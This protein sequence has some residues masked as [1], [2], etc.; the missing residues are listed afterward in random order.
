MD[1]D[2]IVQ[3]DGNLIFGMIEVK[4]FT[5]SNPGEVDFK[6]FFQ[7]SFEGKLKSSQGK[8]LSLEFSEPILPNGKDLA[9]LKVQ[10]MI[11]NADGVEE[12]E[13]ELV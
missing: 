12:D 3:I 1:Q 13:L 11:E 9:I 8:K 4:N 6:E 5:W 2:K 10:A 7:N